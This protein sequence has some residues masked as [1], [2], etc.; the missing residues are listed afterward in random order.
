MA[1]ERQLLAWGTPIIPAIHQLSKDD[2]DA[3]QTQRVRCLLDRL[4]PRVN[5]TPSTLAKL[6]VND[7]TYWSGIAANLSGDQLRLANDNL[8]RFGVEPIAVAATSE[9]RIAASNGSRKD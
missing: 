7:Q 4:R 2:L 1:A 5:D 8:K 6:L 3:E 9:A